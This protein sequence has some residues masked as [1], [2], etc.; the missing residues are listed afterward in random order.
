MSFDKFRRPCA[1]T[2]KALPRASPYAKPPYQYFSL[3]SGFTSFFPSLFLYSSASRSS[4]SKSRTYQ[5]CI[6]ISPF[7]TPVPPSIF[8][9]DTNKALT[10][11]HHWLYPQ[12]FTLRAHKTCNQTKKKNCSPKRPPFKK[13][14][15]KPTHAHPPPIKPATPLRINTHARPARRTEPMILL[16]RPEPIYTHGVEARDPLDAI[17]RRID[18]QIA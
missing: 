6:S 9:W 15:K 13:S 10:N 16:A 11:V 17:A 2:G 12:P 14:P 3:N 7:R 4:P 18:E 5:I 8:T 1:R